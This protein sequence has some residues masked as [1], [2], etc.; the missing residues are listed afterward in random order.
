MVE[1]YMEALKAREYVKANGPMLLVCETYRHMGHSKSDA[2]V[3]R[4]KQ[5]LA[6]WKL[7]DPI[8]RMRNYLIENKY[9]T[10]EETDALDKKAADMIEKAVEFAK[11]K[12]LS[13]YRYDSGRRLCIRRKTCV[14]L[15]MHRR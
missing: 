2:C 9:A 5:E 12:S 10:E 4:T 1:V 11:E 13:V 3:Y 8:I 6:E 15:H 14:R 7:K